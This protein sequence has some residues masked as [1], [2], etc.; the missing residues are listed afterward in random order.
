MSDLIE[1]LRQK[2]EERWPEMIETT[3][4]GRVERWVRR[5]LEI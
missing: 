2:A 1:R 3:L 4:F 5:Q